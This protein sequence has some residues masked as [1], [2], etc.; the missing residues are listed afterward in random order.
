MALFDV[1]RHQA[2][3]LDPGDA[4]D[5]VEGEDR[6]GRGTP[7]LLADTPAQP[8]VGIEAQPTGR[9]AVPGDHVHPGVGQE[10]RGF[11]DRAVVE[12][13]EGLFPEGYLDY[14][15]AAEMGRDLVQAGDHG[16]GH[17][18]QHGIRRW[19]Q[20]SQEDAFSHLAIIDQRRPWK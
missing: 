2:E 18:L 12:L 15:E 19:C 9:G 6:C 13:L 5:L 11:Q 14:P 17:R 8:L 20:H 1:G 10:P 4:E 16:A 7:R 3:S